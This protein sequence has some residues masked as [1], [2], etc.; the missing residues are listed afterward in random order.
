MFTTDAE[1]DGRKEQTLKKSILQGKMRLTVKKKSGGGKRNRETFLVKY[2]LKKKKYNKVCGKTHTFKI[3][4]QQIS[5]ISG[6]LRIYY[7]QSL[8]FICFY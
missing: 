7:E 6:F 2:K 3:H 1:R 8:Y 5:N 4:I